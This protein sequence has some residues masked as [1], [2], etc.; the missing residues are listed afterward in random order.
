MS[1]IYI[2]DISLENENNNGYTDNSN[3]TMKFLLCNKYEK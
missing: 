1:T 2:A 3:K